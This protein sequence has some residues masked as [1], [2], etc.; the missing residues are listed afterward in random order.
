VDHAAVLAYGLA[1]PGA[2][3]D[4]PWEDDLVAKVGGKIF[5]FL[6]GEGVGVKCG[7]NADEAAEWRQRYPE[8][9]SVMAYI[10][11]YGW[12]SVRLDGTVPDD[13]IR[14]LIDASY[15]DVVSRLPKSKRP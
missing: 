4:E 6:G 11:R 15:D 10:G 2:V 13:E 7:R 1:K 8:A 9:V 12:N 3:P 14:E 5:A